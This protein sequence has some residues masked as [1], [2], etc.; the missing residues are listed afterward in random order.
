MEGTLCQTLAAHGGTPSARAVKAWLARLPPGLDDFIGEVLAA[1]GVP[2]DRW[3]R[4]WPG[5]GCCAECAPPWLPSLVDELQLA[6][7]S[8]G[9]ASHLFDALCF[10]VERRMGPDGYAQAVMLEMLSETRLRDMW[11]WE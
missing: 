5:L 10:W 6:G 9:R 3:L 4:I 1:K 2:Q 8:D 7:P 11:H